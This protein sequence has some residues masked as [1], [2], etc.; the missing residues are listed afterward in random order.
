MYSSM[1]VIAY[2]L[3]LNSWC[4][5]QRARSLV[6]SWSHDIQ[7]ANCFPPSV[8]ERATSAKA[9]NT[10]TSEGNSE[11]L[12]ASARDQ[13]VTKGGMIMMSEG[14]S[15]LLPASARDQTVTKGGMIMMRSMFTSSARRVF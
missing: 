6:D 3:L 9:G 14:N 8:H 4:F 10:L 1:Q 12:P 11:L 2:C 5:S 13:T 7:Q 15:A